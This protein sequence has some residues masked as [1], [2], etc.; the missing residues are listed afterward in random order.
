MGKACVIRLVNLDISRE[1]D[2]KI[3]VTSNKLNKDAYMSDYYI[4]ANVD[5]CHFFSQACIKQ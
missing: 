4:E 5:P 2:S 1:V 3:E